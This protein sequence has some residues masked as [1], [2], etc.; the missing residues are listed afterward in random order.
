MVMLPQMKIHPRT[1][2][3]KNPDKIAKIPFVR[4]SIYFYTVAYQSCIKLKDLLFLKEM[5]RLVPDAFSI[6]KNRLLEFLPFFKLKS[7]NRTI[8]YNFPHSHQGYVYFTLICC[9]IGQIN[10]QVIHDLPRGHYSGKSQTQKG[11]LVPY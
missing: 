2:Y 6:L 5:P 3:M 9:Q 4:S 10:T 1:T 8:K 7:F 11:N